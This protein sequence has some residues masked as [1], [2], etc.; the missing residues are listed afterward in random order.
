MEKRTVYVSN[1]A[2]P[3]AGT[4]VTQQ[5]RPD[6]PVSPTSCRAFATMLTISAGTRGEAT[7]G[8]CGK[9]GPL[10]TYGNPGIPVL[11]GLTTLR[12]GAGDGWEGVGEGGPRGREAVGEGGGAA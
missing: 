4:T 11:I 6:S 5:P 10:Q 2:G 7:T 8:Y 9:R 12:D 1:R 3:R